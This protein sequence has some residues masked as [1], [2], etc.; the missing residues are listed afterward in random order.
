MGRV[1]NTPLPLMSQRTPIVTRV[2]RG[3]LTNWAVFNDW[4]VYRLAA[5]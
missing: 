3:V 4:A 1:L 5:D 2:M